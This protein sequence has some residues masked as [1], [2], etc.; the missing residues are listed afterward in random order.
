MEGM[1]NLA[2]NLRETK[3]NLSTQFADWS[4]NFS[5]HHNDLKDLQKP[6]LGEVSIYFYL[7]FICFIFEIIL[8]F[9][10]IST[11]VGFPN[12]LCLFILF[13]LRFSKSIFATNFLLFYSPSQK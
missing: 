8:L 10:F 12:T 11:R 3:S 4:Y 5:P 7:A 13:C 6:K 1:Y 9:E 2:L